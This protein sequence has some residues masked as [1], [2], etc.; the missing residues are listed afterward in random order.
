MINR[1]VFSRYWSAIFLPCILLEISPMLW[2]ARESVGVLLFIMSAKRVRERVTKFWPVSVIVA[3]GFLGKGFL[4][5]VD[6]LCSISKSLS[7]PFV[8]VSSNF[9]VF[10]CYST[11]MR[12]WQVQK[13]LTKTSLDNMSLLL[14]QFYYTHE[15]YYYVI[16][17]SL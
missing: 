13:L 11:S 15:T 16:L 2:N 17:C 14:C 1:T 8:K 4:I 12:L 10:D 6:V 7:F 9:L 3:D 5:V